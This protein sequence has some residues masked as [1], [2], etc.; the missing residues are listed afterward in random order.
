[1]NRDDRPGHKGFWRLE[2]NPKISGWKC[3][4]RLKR[5]GFELHR[6][7]VSWGCITADKDNATTM[8]QYENVNNLLN[9]ENGANT[10]TVEP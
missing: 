4:L 6:G 3:R 9:S 8:Q 2:P 10:L 5:C 7:T 1:M